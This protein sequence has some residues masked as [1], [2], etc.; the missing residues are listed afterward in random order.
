MLATWSPLLESV[1][2]QRG[3]SFD[4]QLGVAPG[5]HT[6]PLD[7]GVIG[8]LPMCAIYNEPSRTKWTR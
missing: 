6:V 8:S 3:S 5:S 2:A 4:G 1:E 7:F